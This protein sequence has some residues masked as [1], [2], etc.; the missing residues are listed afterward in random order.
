MSF[1]EG[2]IPWQG[3]LKFRIYSPGENKKY[4]VLVRMVCETE[5]YS[6]TDLG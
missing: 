2:M 3:S 1:D 6:H 4:G 5:I